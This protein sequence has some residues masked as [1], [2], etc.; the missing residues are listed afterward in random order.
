MARCAEEQEC[1]IRVILDPIENQILSRAENDTKTINDQRFPIHPDLI[2]V[3]PGMTQ[4][5]EK[6]VHMYV[7]MYVHSSAGILDRVENDKE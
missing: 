7:H 2:G 1:F 6:Y 4:S 3:K 5:G